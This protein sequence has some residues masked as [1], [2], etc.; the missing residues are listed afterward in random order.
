[1]WTILSTLH[2]QICQGRVDKNGTFDVPLPT[3]G[4]DKS[5]IPGFNKMGE[6]TGGSPFGDAKESGNVFVG[7]VAF[8]PRRCEG[9][10]LHQEDLLVPGEVGVL[11]YLQRNPYALYDALHRYSSFPAL[12]LVNVTDGVE[13]RL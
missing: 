8:L 1:M 9:V 5:D 12:G 3:I 7:D 2:R 10:D 11:P 13:V 4:A 6:T